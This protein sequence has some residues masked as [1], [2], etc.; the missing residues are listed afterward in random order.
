MNKKLY[1]IPLGLVIAIY[2]YWG[3]KS[4]KETAHE[5]YIEFYN[6]DVVGVITKVDIGFKSTELKINTLDKKFYF[7]SID[8]ELN[9]FKDFNYLA[10]KGDSVYKPA[11]SDTLVLVRRDQ[12]H[13]N[14][15][16]SFTFRKY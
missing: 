13:A 15:K 2:I 14:Q 7:N 4:T 5:H 16:H 6:A 3:N 11:Q 10:E 8:S 1:F 12:K 9:D